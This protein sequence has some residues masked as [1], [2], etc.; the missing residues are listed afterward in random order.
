[1]FARLVAFVG[2][3]ARRRRISAEVDDELRFHVEQ[4]IESYVARGVSLTIEPF[5]RVRR[6]LGRRRPQR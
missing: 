4:E 3:I 5:N 6:V 1:M 2:G